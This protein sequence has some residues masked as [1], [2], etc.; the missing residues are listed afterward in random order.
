LLNQSLHTN[1]RTL[2]CIIISRRLV[3]GS[4]CKNGQAA[5]CWCDALCT[6]S[7]WIHDIS[8][9][10]ISNNPCAQSRICMFRHGG[11]EAYLQ[12]ACSIVVKDGL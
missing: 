5:D 6:S 9:P 10:D 3:L 1:M 12:M 4:S 7:W 2:Y 11:N 8:N